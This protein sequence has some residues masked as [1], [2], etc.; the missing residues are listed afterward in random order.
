MQLLEAPYHLKLGGDWRNLSIM[1]TDLQGFSSISERMHLQEL[2]NLL[3]TSLS[4][5]TTIIL[6]E[7]GTLDTYE[8][9]AIVA[10]WNAPL[11]SA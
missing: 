9:D 2:T 5:M 4:D 1:F 3:N 8:G 10:F 6:D 11:E 7:S